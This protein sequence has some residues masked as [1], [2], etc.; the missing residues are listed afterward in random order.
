MNSLLLT[1]G[2]VIDPA[3]RLDL[4]ADL[5]I[6]EG[7][8]SRVGQEAQARAGS[9]VPRLD[10][11]GLIVCPGL[12]D[13]HVHLREPGQSAKETI[14]TGTAAAA[15]GGF[16]SVVCMPN[17][18]PAIDNA[19]TVALIREK[20]AREGVVNV[21]VTGAITRSIAGE[22]LA[23]IGSLKQAGVI[24]IT[25]DGHCIQNNELMR[26]ALEY[27]R[28]FDLPVLD[29]CQDYALV[30]DGVVHEG[31]WSTVLGLRGWPSAGEEAI[32]AR[33]ILLA[34]LTG[35]HVHCQH[36]SA[37]GSVQLLREARK[38]G[39]PI[40]GEAC[41]HHFMLTDAAIA[42]SATFWRTDGMSLVHE[43]RERESLPEW[44]P[45]DTN[46][47][48]NPPL[49]S[50]RDRE[51]ILEGLA[52]G[53]IEILG[54]DHAPHC[55]YEKEVEFD[56]APFGITG[57]E[58]ELALSLMQL[59]HTERL[60]LTELIAKF[61]VHPARLLRLAKGT[62][63]VGADADVTVFDPEREWVFE[64]T[65]SCSKAGNSPFYGWTLKGKAVATIVGGKIVWQEQQTALLV[66]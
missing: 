53:T 51:A 61:T 14:A 42:G 31:Y 62:L 35:A 9:D 12:I 63:S 21:F 1:G 11:S 32:V 19:G 5:L 17:T 25:D 56:Y 36:L 47:K 6:H 8:I 52:D 65:A 59:V 13:S 4:T 49:R 18:S 26:R 41:P 39:V 16:T 15:R 45:Y 38:R 57:L 48:M 46:F 24:A 29:H 60:S 34:E 28:M 33:N 10:V 22:E 37:A 20:A 54:S 27:A 40:S 44:P 2:R 50:A 64:R 23:P 58:T 66:P 7:K 55:D 3:N 43:Q 30:T